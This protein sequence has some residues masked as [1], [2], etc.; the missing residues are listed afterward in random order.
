VGSNPAVSKSSNF[1]LLFS[2]AFSFLFLV[3]YRSLLKYWTAVAVICTY[4]SLDSG[5]A[6]VIFTELESE[7]GRNRQAGDDI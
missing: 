2:S 6:T 7:R 5:N 1:A 4:N 3:S